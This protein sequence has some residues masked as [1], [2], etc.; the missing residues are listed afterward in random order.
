MG[1]VR[2]E[3]GGV[4]PEGR[5]LRGGI[6]VLTGRYVRAVA[7]A[8]VHGVPANARSCRWAAGQ[9]ENRAGRPATQ[10]CVGQC[11]PTASEPLAAAPRGFIDEA[12]DKAVALVRRVVPPFPGQVQHVEHQ[13]GALSRRAT[14]AGDRTDFADG[15]RPP[16]RNDIR[17]ALRIPLLELRAEAVIEGVPAV[18][19]LGGHRRNSNSVG[20]PLGFCSQAGYRGGIWSGDDV[21]SSML[22]LQ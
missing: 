11:S 3:S 12:S 14:R 17:H 13:A 7:A 19:V 18:R 2:R 10:K 20:Q 22:G 21:G 15:V 5:I 6:D 1:F 8:N 16:V 4:P 9:S